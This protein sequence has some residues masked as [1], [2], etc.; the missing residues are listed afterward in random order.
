MRAASMRPLS[1]PG[2]TDTVAAIG[3]LDV[4]G[5][6]THPAVAAHPQS[7]SPMATTSAPG[8]PHREAIP[9][10]RAVTTLTHRE[11]GAVGSGFAGANV[12]SPD[13]H[14]WMDETTA[15]EHWKEGGGS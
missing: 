5:R 15:A 1:G 4:P 9:G 6:E 10:E 14:A 13:R 12:P 11:P 7:S 3:A 2:S 8:H